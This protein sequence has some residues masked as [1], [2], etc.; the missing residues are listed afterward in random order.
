MR[1]IYFTFAIFIIFNFSSN[2]ENF[3]NKSLALPCLGCHGSGANSS[4]PVIFG[5]DENYIYINLM[6]YKLD[7][8]DHYLMNLIAKGYTNDQLLALA[9][10][11]SSIG[12]NDE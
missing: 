9:E 3:Y 4:I 1:Y 7:K 12:K 8:R 6:D 2:A 10:Y 11:F 5:L